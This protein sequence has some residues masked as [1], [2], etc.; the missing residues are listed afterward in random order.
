M[1]KMHD[2]TIFWIIVP[3]A[4]AIAAVVSALPSTITQITSFSF[5]PHGFCYM[6]NKQLLTLHVVSDSLIFLSYLAI[7]CAIAWLLRR[8]RQ[9]L[10]FAWIFVAF[11]AFIVACGLTHA[12][13]VVAL[14]IPLYWLAGDIKLITAIASVIT[15][16]A[17][18]LLVPKV[19]QVLRQ[20]ATSRLNEL[21][22]LGAAESSLDCLYLA[23]AA[24]DANG[25]IEDFVFTYVNGNA[26]R[27]VTPP[28]EEL[29]GGRMCELFPVNRKI[30]I[31]DK[32]KHVVL[33]GEP[34]IGE[35]AIQEE[36]IRTAWLRVQAAK[37]GDGV[38]I[39]ASDITERKRK[40]EV[41]RKSA[42]LLERTGRLTDTGGWEVDLITSEV[43]WSA[44]L[45]RIHGVA[46]D[47]RPTLAEGIEFYV[48]EDRDRI[49]AAVEKATACGDGFD[50]ECTILRRDGT[51]VPVRVVGTAE[52]QNG[53]PVR[54]NGALK[55]I[56]QQ[57]AERVALTAAKDR[58]SLAA[59]SGGIGIW[60]W[61]IAPDHLSWDH[62]MY[63]LYGME[64]RDN[65]EAYEL[66]R[67]RVHPED[68]E[69]IERH[70]RDAMAGVE[71]LNCEFRIVWDDGSV[72]HIRATGLVTHNEAGQPVRMVGTNADVTARKEGELELAKLADFMHSIISS[73]P[74]ATIVTNLAGV[75]TSMNPAAERML[76]YR[77][78]DL[79]DQQTPMVLLNAQEVANRSAALSEE[80]HMTV[81]PGF[82]VLTANPRRGRLEEAEWQLIRRDGARID[83]QLTVSALTDSKSVIVGYILIAYDITERKRAQEYIAHL[84]HHDAMTGLPTRT[85]FRDRLD[86]AL[87]GAARCQR[88]VGVLMIDLDNFKRINDLMGHHVGD[89]LL[90]VIAKRLR[91]C[92]RASD[93]VARMGGDEFTVVLDELSAAEDAE[94]VAEKIVREIAMPVSIGSH[95]I[96]PTASIG[97]SVYPETGL[98]TEALLMNAD[99]AMYR[100]KAE[101]RNGRRIYSRELESAAARKRA[102]QECLNQ[103]LALNE[104]ELVYQPQIC[105]KTGMVNGLEALLRWRSD[106]LGVVMPGEFI[107]LAEENG[108]IVPIGEWVLRTACRQGRQLQ[109]AVG[110][111]LT[112]A[113][114]ISPR[115]FQQN[116]L[117]Q[118]IGN[119]LAESGLS[120]SSLEL[121]ITEN[122]LIGDLPRPRAL[123]EQIR[124][125]GVRI[126]IDDF[127]TGFSSM[128]YILRIRV[129][130][131]KIDQSFIRGMELDPDSHAV[132]R[133]VVALAK[134]LHIPVV[135][136]GVETAA[137]RDML[138]GE[139]CDEAQ[140]YFYSR[141][142]PME[143]I[144][145]AI[146]AIEHPEAVAAMA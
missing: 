134:G 79:I 109:L 23:D 136:E 20:A 122:V 33:T 89:E 52:F 59:D 135:A 108:M 74:F 127:G 4:A 49:R 45:Y 119:I 3:I 50:M 64:P 97:V 24:R 56:S 32:Y 129:D 131:L 78:E 72:H 10:P 39:T 90:I 5:L 30:G 137:H 111:A 139:G 88:K 130:R 121:E 16:V 144:C 85:L 95:V 128:S 120:A 7:S 42:A 31:F 65:T 81:E 86:A 110:R 138:L 27:L 40:D 9:H 84:A 98:T 92:V 69:S 106:K 125:L 113:V 43:F 116:D 6:W 63:R 145:A 132:T 83:A 11:G 18:P 37:L 141:P 107:E 80:L 96:H 103:A 73:S 15:A 46:P 104:F 48:P 1:R 112:I 13:D 57:V 8:E 36:N 60:D 21:R 55:D 29:I 51:Q 93:T 99:A 115:Q 101:G 2:R 53:K 82:G 143:D 35:F 67:Q 94:L 28:I 133:A 26:A 118:M 146:L 140:G 87:A 142:R 123:L 62:W 91:N 66:W 117:P 124:S 68:I 105:M 38:A 102:L 34:F 77:R 25:E 14:W 58:L 12:M 71:A 47:Y 75:I 76:W 19:G 41:I 70:I 100:T 114:N 61:E 22:F 44:E 54:L 126:A 17:L